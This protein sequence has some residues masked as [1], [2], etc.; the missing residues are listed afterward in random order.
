MLNDRDG[1]PDP[2]SQPALDWLEASVGCG[3]DVFVPVHTTTSCRHGTFV[4][5]INIG[6]CTFIAGRMEWSPVGALS[7]LTGEGLCR[8]PDGRFFILVKIEMPDK[9]TEEL[10]FL[11]TLTQE[12]A[13][14]ITDLEAARWVAYDPEIALERMRPLVEKFDLTRPPADRIELAAA[15]PSE[16]GTAATGGTPLAGSSR[17]FKDLAAAPEN[18]MPKAPKSNLLVDDLAVAA[19]TRLSKEEGRPPS[20]ARVA[21]EIGHTRQHL[22]DCPTFMSLVRTEKEKSE[23]RKRDFPRGVKDRFGRVEAHRDE[24]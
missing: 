10:A 9:M 6:E 20:I 22:Y 13:V 15:E 11:L 21:R 19:W 12:Y 3:L 17:N 1:A 16:N 24:D 7:A 14:F 8:T 4:G 5:W 2:P 23:N 18:S